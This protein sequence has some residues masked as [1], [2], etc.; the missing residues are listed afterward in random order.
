[1]NSYNQ[2]NY[3]LILN[4]LIILYIYKNDVYKTN[5]F[6]L[7]YFDILNR[8]FLDCLFLVEDDDKKLFNHFNADV[9][10]IAKNTM[11]ENNQSILF[12]YE[13]EKLWNKKSL[14]TQLVL[15]FKGD[16][17]LI[18][19]KTIYVENNN[20]IDN[21]LN[22][23]IY[24]TIKNNPIN[25]II[26]FKN[27]VDK[28]LTS[29][30]LFKNNMN[31]FIGIT[32]LPI[33]YYQNK[34]LVD[35][36]DYLSD[37]ALLISCNPNFEFKTNNNFY[38]EL[39]SLFIDNLIMF[40]SSKID[41]YKYVIKSLYESKQKEFLY[42]NLLDTTDNDKKWLEIRIEYEDIIVDF[43]SVENLIWYL[44]NRI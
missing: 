44:K 15:F 32:N 2:D 14:Y 24:L 29:N 1:M 27:K 35:L 9:A 36:Y 42:R 40:D 25:L 28:D 6:Y 3:Y 22:E 30:Y 16:F 7:K 38:I 41:D 12:V 18:N 10:R 34:N 21:K 13:F 26:N 11:I 8:K 31:H 20:Q 33:G 43:E 37:N 5:S 4:Y 19:N 39:I 23:S 17:N